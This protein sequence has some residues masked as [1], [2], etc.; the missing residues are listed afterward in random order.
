M[1]PF[2]LAKHGVRWL[3][4][5]ACV[6]AFSTT[7]TWAAD[8]ALTT[9]PLLTPSVAVHSSV[10]AAAIV[11]TGTVVI[12]SSRDPDGSPVEYLCSTETGRF[13][14]D[15]LELDPAQL[16]STIRDVCTSVAQV[17]AATN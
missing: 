4:P 7:V 15:V 16:T 8:R 6:A 11:P 2:S 3:L 10:P 1:R 5:I 17:G 14:A 12:L 13:A 9:I